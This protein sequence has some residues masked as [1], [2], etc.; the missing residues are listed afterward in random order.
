MNSNLFFWRL[1]HNK[2]LHSMDKKIY[3]IE[4]STYAQTHHLATVNPTAHQPSK[5]VAIELHFGPGYPAPSQ[6]SLP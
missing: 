4:C 1:Y 2:N 6:P 3:S 5:T